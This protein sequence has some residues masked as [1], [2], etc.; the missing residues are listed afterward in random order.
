MYS[1]K[2]KIRYSQVDKHGRLNIQALVHYLQDASTMHSDSLNM[3][4]EYLRERHRAWVLNSWQIDLLEEINYRDEIVI[5]TWPY[6]NKGIYG[7]RNFSVTDTEGKTLVKTNSLWIYLN[8]ETGLPERVT[9]EEIDPYGREEKLDMEYLN[10]KIKIEGEGVEKDSF[11]I[12]KYHIDTNGHV[13]NGWY[14]QFAQEYLPSEVENGIRHLKRLR[15]E[16]KNAAVYGDIIYPM[17]Y[18]EENKSIVSLNDIDGNAY[19]VV[20]W[21]Y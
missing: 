18:V 5:N 10:R 15:V 16:Y 4:V 20:E 12:R 21:N 2:D 7:Y 6:D 13:N 8:T 3:G 14:I 11:P 17:V 9:P 1:Y 19:C